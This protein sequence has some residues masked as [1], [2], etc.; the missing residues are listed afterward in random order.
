MHDGYDL[1][2]V[3]FERN[4]SNTRVRRNEAEKHTLLPLKY[5]DAKMTQRVPQS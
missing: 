2:S 1:A 3:F 5:S 4:V